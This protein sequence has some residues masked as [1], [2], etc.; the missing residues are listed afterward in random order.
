[1]Y[2][3]YMIEN[4]SISEFRQNLAGFLEKLKTR[5]NYKIRLMDRK[6][7]LLTLVKEQTLEEPKMNAGAALL[8]AAKKIKQLNLK[9]KD[10]A[11]DVSEHIDHYLYGKPLD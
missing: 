2:I 11:T 9:P 1:M 5:A 3:M 8:E 10:S 6:R 7:P 4:I